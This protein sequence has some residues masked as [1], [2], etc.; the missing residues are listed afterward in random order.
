M[1][2]YLIFRTDRIGDFLLT[3]ILIKSI[4][5][6][7]PN[8][9]ISIVSSKKN[10]EYINSFDNIDKVYFLKKGFINNLKLIFSL[11]K[12]SYNSIIIHDYKNKSKIIS[13]F[14]KSKKKYI[15]NKKKIVSYIDEIKNIL[16]FLNFNFDNVDLNSLDNRNINNYKFDHKD[17]ILFHFDE[18]WIYNE[19]IKSYVNIEPTEKLLELFLDSLYLKFNKNIIVTTGVKTPT[20]LENVFK[21]N[22]NNKIKLIKNSNFIDLECLINNSSLLISCHGAISHV[23]AAKNIKQI[24][25]I[26][27][28]YNYSK[29]TKHFRKY[30]SVNRKPFNELSFEILNLNFI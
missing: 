20:I 22:L 13:F 25:I 28:S 14:L 8:S 24:D 16:K 3:A 2:N 5:R 26:D 29:W 30:K 4:K 12:V 27:A 6:N 18:K 17:Y 23:A 10:Y 21:K 7:D 11:Y 15:S 9:I 19:Y 1:N